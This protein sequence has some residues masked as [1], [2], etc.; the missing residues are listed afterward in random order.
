MSAA[1]YPQVQKS[2]LPTTAVLPTRLVC[3]IGL[4]NLLQMA[5]A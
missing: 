4:V 1:Y 3:S 5:V 2:T